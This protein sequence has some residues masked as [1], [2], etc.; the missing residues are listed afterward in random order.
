MD[1]GFL[2]T[3]NNHVTFY[4]RQHFHLKN[5][6]LQVSAH[7]HFFITDDRNLKQP[8]KERQQES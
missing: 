6:S 3:L 8:Q 4:K 1:F 5:M 2:L 7:S